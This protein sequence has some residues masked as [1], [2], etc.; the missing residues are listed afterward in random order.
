MKGDKG[1]TL[2]ILPNNDYIKKIEEFIQSSNFVKLDNDPTN[3]FQKSFRDTLKKC[4]YA[5]QKESS[6]KY[7]NMNP[8]PPYMYGLIKL[9]KQENPIQPVINS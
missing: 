1:N 2:V 9:H 3:R 8:K 5:V 6:Q 7:I 4:Q